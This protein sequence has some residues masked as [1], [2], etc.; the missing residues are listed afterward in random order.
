M[1]EAPCTGLAMMEFLTCCFQRT[2]E[3]NAATFHAAL[4]MLGFLQTILLKSLSKSLVA[5]VEAEN[6]ATWGVVASNAAT[7][8]C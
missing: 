3:A 7:F 5:A 2:V 6:T 8:F 1:V 4:V